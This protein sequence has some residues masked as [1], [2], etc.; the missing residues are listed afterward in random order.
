MIE[1]C[2]LKRHFPSVPYARLDG[3]VP[4]ITR[5]TIAKRFNDQQGTAITS[6]SFSAS[7][8]S[9]SP[10]RLLLMTTRA[11]GLGLN[12]TAADIVIFVEHDWNPFVDLQAMDRVHRIGQTQPVTVYRLLAE[13]TIE[14]RIMGLQSLKHKVSDEIIND[15][16]AVTYE[17]GLAAGGSTVGGAAGGA[18]GGGAVDLGEEGGGGLGLALWDSMLV[19]NSL[20]G[21]NEAPTRATAIEEYESLDLETFLRS[22]DNTR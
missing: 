4:P 20:D 19:A 22:I 13:T 1:E 9:S 15:S 6:S 17:K 16:N 10:L 8:P 2:V 7:S 11:C 3:D 12:L 21:R 18:A 5:S 14:A